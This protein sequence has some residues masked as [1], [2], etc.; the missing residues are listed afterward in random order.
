MYNLKKVLITFLV[1]IT[2]IATSLYFVKSGYAEN[3]FKDNLKT[4]IEKF[5]SLDKKEQ[6]RVKKIIKE[7]NFNDS[8]KISLFLQQNNSLGYAISQ[9]D[10]IKSVVYGNNIK[11]GYDQYKNYF[12]VYGEKPNINN[13]RLEITIN[14]GYNHD[15]IVKIISLEEGKYFLSID[16]LPKDIKHS[17]VYTE[18]FRYN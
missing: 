18:N 8:Y 16:K 3:T 4:K 12:I 10:K 11:Q 7:K 13:K 14:T 9:H 15:D 5:S 6:V 1:F 17:N 2:L